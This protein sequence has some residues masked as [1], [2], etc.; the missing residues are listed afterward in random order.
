MPTT[1]PGIS[2]ESVVLRVI[3]AL[4]SLARSPL[5]WGLIDIF[6]SCLLDAAKSICNSWQPVAPHVSAT[7]S[8]LQI[9]APQSVRYKGLFN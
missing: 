8:G 4:A 3:L 1:D 5:P 2:A 6:P 9:F 7:G